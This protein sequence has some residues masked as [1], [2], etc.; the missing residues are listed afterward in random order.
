MTDW[1]DILNRDGPAAWKTAWR[2]LGNRA[3]ADECF[4]EACMAAFEFAA[5]QGAKTISLGKRI[6]RSETASIAL[7]AKILI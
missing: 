6:L 2:V 1:D 5:K 7:L 3:D 4:Q